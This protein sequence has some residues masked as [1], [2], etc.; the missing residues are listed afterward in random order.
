[1]SFKNWSERHPESVPVL[2]SHASCFKH[3]YFEEVQF[4]GHGVTLAGCFRPLWPERCR[5]SS[6]FSSTMCRACAYLSGTLPS[7][8]YLTELGVDPANTRSVLVRRLQT[9]WDS[10]AYAMPSSSAASMSSGLQSATELAPALPKRGRNAVYVDKAALA[11]HLCRQEVTA[12]EQ[13]T[14]SKMVAKLELEMACSLRE[15]A[16]EWSLER[17]AVLADNA[18]LLHENQQLRKDVEALHK[19]SIEGNGRALFDKAVGIMAESGE[20]SLAQSSWAI[21][22]KKRACSPRS[23]MSDLHKDLSILA[24]FE[25]KKQSYD[26]FRVFLGLPKYSH[27]KTLRTKHP[28]YVEYTVGNN[29]KAWALGTRRFD[30]QCVLVSSD[31]TRWVRFIDLLRKMGLVG[32]GF[33]PDIRKW[34]D[35]PDPV[36]PEYEDIVKYVELCRGNPTLLAHELVTVAIH[37]VTGQTANFLPTMVFPEPA[38]GFDAFSHSL[39]MMECAKYCW[40]Y[41]IMCCGDC[42]DSCST[43]HCGGLEIMTPRK[44][45]ISIW[46][47]G[48]DIPG[49]RY[50][51]CL[52]AV[53]DCNGVVTEFWWSWYG[54]APHTERNLRKGVARPANNLVTQVFE[55]KTQHRAMLEELKFVEELLDPAKCP[56]PTFRYTGASLKAM[57]TVKK[58]RDQEGDSAKEMLMMSTMEAM[59]VTRG[60]ASY[61]LLLYILV[62][63]YL[64]EVFVN[65][66]FTHPYLIALYAWTSRMLLEKLETYVECKELPKDICL[67]STTTRRTMDSMSHTAIHHVLKMFRKHQDGALDLGPSFEGMSLAR[68]NTKPMEGYHGTQRTHGNDFNMT[69]GEWIVSM[70]DMVMKQNLIDRLKVNFKVAVGAPRNTQKENRGRFRTFAMERP[71]AVLHGLIGIA[72]EV[73]PAHIKYGNQGTPSEVVPAEF[74]VPITSYPQLLEVVTAGCLAAEANAVAIY[75]EL[76]WVAAKELKERGELE[77]SKAWCGRPIDMKIVKEDGHPCAPFEPAGAD[78][79]TKPTKVQREEEKAAALIQEVDVENAGAQRTLPRKQATM[80]KI[81]KASKA[82]ELLL[83]AAGDTK[84]AIGKVFLEK[85]KKVLVFTEKGGDAS[86]IYRNRVA[87]TSDGDL[88]Y[89]I[90]ILKDLQPREWV[91]RERGPRFWVGVLPEWRLL[92]PGHNVSRG[93]LFVVQYGSPDK[94]LVAL[95]RVQRIHIGKESPKSCELK[96]NSKQKFAMELCLEQECGDLPGGAVRFVASGRS[97]PIMSGD[98]VY[99]TVDVAREGIGSYTAIMSGADVRLWENN[100]RWM[101]NVA[102]MEIDGADDPPQDPEDPEDDVESNVEELCC[103]CMRGWWDDVS[104]R[105]LHCT[106]KCARAFHAACMDLHELKN[107]SY[108]CTRCTG[109]DDAI[110]QVCDKEW[111]CD[112]RLNEDKSFNEFYSGCMLACHDCGLWYHQ[113]CHNPKIEDKYV[114]QET[115]AEACAIKKKGKKKGRAGNK[116]DLKW[117]CDSCKPVVGAM[118]VPVAVATDAPE[119]APEDAPEEVPAPPVPPSVPAPPSRAPSSRVRNPPKPWQTCDP[120]QQSG[121]WAK[122]NTGQRDGK[123]ERLAELFKHPTG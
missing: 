11:L 40:K 84:A 6:D 41:G 49:F 67:L 116:K 26:T 14:H 8:G 123:G 108:I 24:L 17:D 79:V 52:I 72:A 94:K 71:P 12:Q 9:L 82:V 39:L 15:L 28:D 53:G 2:Q 81:R 7:R 87:L 107:D 101:R 44:G 118:A 103:R 27:A 85:G 121:T 46:W 45:K 100:G 77:K 63:F 83:Q 42:T 4:V 75:S 97:L 99:G 34:P 43:G 64:Y 113:E 93:T 18:R 68:V 114:V 54:D 47:M 112:E 98:K 36:P 91:N 20:M 25:M 111:Y 3:F 73:S 109:E 22:W 66:N 115:T 92:P 1:M 104:G 10:T 89:I 117:F 102:E 16:N 35:G 29:P 70:S 37:G 90:A 48:V 61:P 31:G 86:G 74:N 122:V 50:W 23:K 65:P 21:D 19:A 5:A 62:G 38:M 58:F 33:P 59:V 60:K 57:R 69:P 110:C 13:E 55:D 51:A 76:A 105:L 120:R 106:G 119:E 95:C 30:K 56:D 32:R 88:Q 78:G 96:C 80:M